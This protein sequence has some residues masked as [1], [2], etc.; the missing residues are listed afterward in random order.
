MAAQPLNS[1]H[2]ALE[3]R[4]VQQCE[5]LAVG[6]SDIDARHLSEDFDNAAGPSTRRDGRM[7]RCV[8]MGVL[9]QRGWSHR[10]EFPTVKLLDLGMVSAR[11][12]RDCH[13]LAS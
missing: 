12:P 11:A 13:S 1:Q 5:A 9:Q 4:V 3:G 2:M 8:C 10:S 6:G 7:Q